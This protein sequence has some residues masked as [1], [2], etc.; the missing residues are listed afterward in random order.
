MTTDGEGGERCWGQE[1]WLLVLNL[2]SAFLSISFLIHERL[3]LKGSHSLSDRFL[4]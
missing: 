4:P 3:A 2:S 1:R